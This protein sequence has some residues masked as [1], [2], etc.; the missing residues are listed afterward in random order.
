V[1]EAIGKEDLA[2][3]SLRFSF[4]KETTKVHIDILVEAL[5]KIIKHF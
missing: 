4:G 5:K 3:N 1:I 2:Q